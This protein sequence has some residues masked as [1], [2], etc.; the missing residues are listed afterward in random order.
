[1]RERGHEITLGPECSGVTSVV[2]ALSGCAP[3]TSQKS[4][5]AEGVVACSRLMFWGV[6]SQVTSTSARFEVGRWLRPATGPESVRVAFSAAANQPWQSDPGRVL[7]IIP[8]SAT[9]PTFASGEAAADIERYAG[10]IV[11]CPATY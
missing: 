11:P 8:L 6:P 1:M 5:S 4:L 9:E 10:T 7:V 2:V 3:T